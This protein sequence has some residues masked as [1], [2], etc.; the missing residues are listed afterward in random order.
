MKLYKAHGWYIP[1]WYMCRYTGVYKKYHHHENTQNK[2]DN[3]RRQYRFEKI[4]E[5]G[6][7]VNDNVSLLY[8]RFFHSRL[9][10]HVQKMLSTRN[11]LYK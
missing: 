2:R 5:N 8:A 3:K 9:D 4:K 1:I 6:G 7:A 11:T 10:I